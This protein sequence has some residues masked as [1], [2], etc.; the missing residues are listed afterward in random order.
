ME[1]YEREATYARRKRSISRCRSCWWARSQ[2]RDIGEGR[3]DASETVSD[4]ELTQVIHDWVLSG[5]QTFSCGDGMAH[6]ECCTHISRSGRQQG[7]VAV[8]WIVATYSPAPIAVHCSELGIAC[9][10]QINRIGGDQAAKVHT[11]SQRNLGIFLRSRS[12][13]GTGGG[14]VGR[15][16]RLR[17]YKATHR[18]ELASAD[19]LWMNRNGGGCSSKGRHLVAKTRLLISQP[20]TGIRD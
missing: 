8:V 13:S 15:D 4:G 5:L 2:E 6:Y 3:Q 1:S 16:Y 17:F 7:L 20:V 9:Q 18:Y 10:L 11:M 19:Q 12:L 14:G